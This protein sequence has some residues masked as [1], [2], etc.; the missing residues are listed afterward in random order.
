MIAQGDNAGRDYKRNSFCA[1]KANTEGNTIKLANTYNN[2]LIK[3]LPKKT[4]TSAAVS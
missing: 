2:K 1:D 4:Q 3:Q